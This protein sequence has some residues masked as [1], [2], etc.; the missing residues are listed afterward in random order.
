LSRPDD[1]VR[2]SVGLLPPLVFTRRAQAFQPAEPVSEKSDFQ[3]WQIEV[4]VGLAPV[5]D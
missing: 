5:L 3:S 2:P 1:Y 4:S